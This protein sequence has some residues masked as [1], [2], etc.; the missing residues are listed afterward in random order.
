M[1]SE[2]EEYIA[3][4]KRIDC[5]F[6]YGDKVA[7]TRL[8]REG[9]SICLDADFLV[10]KEISS[11]GR[12]ARV[13]SKRQHELVDEWATGFEHPLKEPLLQCARLSI[14]GKKL[15]WRDAISLMER[16]GHFDGQYTAL[17]IAYFAGE[18]DGEEGEAELEAAYEQICQR[19]SSKGV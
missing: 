2:H 15:F 19:W 7:S 11:K 6:P 16:I 13:T 9:R 3:F 8:I 4:S 1:P 14:D 10:L 5:K 12:S 17:S 18:P